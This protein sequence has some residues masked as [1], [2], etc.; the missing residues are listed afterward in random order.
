MSSLLDFI[1]I[2]F[3]TDRYTAMLRDKLDKQIN[4]DYR[5]AILEQEVEDSQDVLADKREQ[6]S[7]RLLGYWDSLGEDSV[8]F[9]II[10]K[11]ILKVMRSTYKVYY[12]DNNLEYVENFIWDSYRRYIY[13]ESWNLE[14]SAAFK[15]EDG[16]AAHLKRD[17]KATKSK[18]WK[19]LSLEKFYKECCYD[20]EDKIKFDGKFHTQQKNFEEEVEKCLQEYRDVKSVERSN[21]SEAVCEIYGWYG[22]E[23]NIYANVLVGERRNIE[24]DRRRGA[25]GRRDSSDVASDIV[26][27]SVKRL[28]MTFEENAEEDILDYS[29]AI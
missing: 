8:P 1:I 12:L 26:Y 27:Y 25:L 9:S 18:V 11:N 5:L 23:D 19:A 28:G 17:T 13:Q 7:L 15:R 10:R 24:L 3:Q 2:N 20:I 22:E 21:L 4:A 29:A 14:W 6:C 16:F